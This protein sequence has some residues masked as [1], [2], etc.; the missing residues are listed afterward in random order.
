VNPGQI[1]LRERPLRFRF[2]VL[3]LLFASLLP[4]E[5]L[6]GDAGP[7]L[8]SPPGTTYFVAI[9]GDDRA[10]GSGDRPWATLNHAADMAQAG[11]RIV[12]RGGEYTLMDQVRPRASGRADAWIEYIGFPG[13]KVVLDAHHIARPS[14]SAL[15]NG[16]FQ[17]EGVSYIRVANLIVVNSHDAGFTIRDASHAELINNTARETFSSGIA[18]WD[19][20]HHRSTA[21]DIRIIGNTV[22][23][24]NTWHMAPPDELGR[25]EPPHEA[26]SIGGAVDFEI[27][28]NLVEDSDK[29][30]IDVKETSGRGSVHHNF[31]HRMRSQGI[32]VDAWFGELNDVDISSN[33][34]AECH[35][36]GIAVSVENGIAVGGVT[37]SRN[38]VFAND[39]SGLYFSRWGADGPRRDIRIVNNIFYHNGYGLPA[40][41]QEYYW[42]TGGIYLYSD[43]L[44]NVRI[45]NNILSE[46]RGFQIGYSELWLKEQGSWQAVARQ[47]GIR[48]IRN[49]F[50]DTSGPAS[51]RSG[52]NPADAVQVH[53]FTGARACFADPGFRG[54][55]V[56]DLS[57]Q[58]QPLKGCGAGASLH[59]T[60]EGNWWKRNFPPLFI[61]K[62][63]GEISIRASASGPLN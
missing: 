20:S 24:A 62:N 8:L 14:P 51:I 13:E 57:L 2:V 15:S 38:I 16:A 59:W 43:R 53:A 3:G 23:R 11:D 61:R 48:V 52:G 27:A 30:G 34:V 31:V 49:Q 54:V 41:G 9:N 40:P 36:A 37:I 22:R 45:E 17:I 12:V 56:L 60:R 42:Q 28:Y 10:P 21:H 18:V 7:K 33:V 55:S 25:S 19:T 35:G 39:G 58:R 32:Y 26:I 4:L 47:Q 44:E 1:T 63:G 46:N 6:A 50:D 29:E 5:L